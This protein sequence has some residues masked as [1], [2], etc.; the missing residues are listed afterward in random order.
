M[1]MTEPMFEEVPSPAI[2]GLESRI[3]RALAA[4]PDWERLEETIDRLA[5]A[6]EGSKAALDA[7]GTQQAGQ[8]ARLADF[9]RRLE[10]AQAGSGTPQAPAAPQE[11][12]ARLAAVEGGVRRIGEVT[13][14]MATMG[15]RLR[16]LEARQHTLEARLSEL[17]VEA[18][19]SGIKG[20]A[21]SDP[22]ASESGASGLSL[23]GPEDPA[24]ALSPAP[25]HPLVHSQMQSLTRQVADLSVQVRAFVHASESADRE[26]HGRLESLRQA[27]GEQIRKIGGAVKWLA[28][29]LGLAPRTLAGGQG[30]PTPGPGQTGPAQGSDEGMVP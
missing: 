9:E 8:V 19:G 12:L 2:E 24:I 27:T 6:Y 3:E 30:M 4:F 18:A 7:L 14:V 22:G 11:I 21:A 17:V 5:L 10:A 26:L 16:G 28:E 23:A 13:A 25:V 29:R 15:D 20:P 1:G